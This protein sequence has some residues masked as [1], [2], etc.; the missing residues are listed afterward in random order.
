MS[1]YDIDEVKGVAGL[2]PYEKRLELKRNG[3]G[4][5]AICPWHEDHHPS[6]A[7]YERNDEFCFKCFSC[8]A[9][10]D[11]IAFV[12][13]MDGIQFKQALDEV[14]VDAGFDLQTQNH[15]FEFDLLKAVDRLPEAE[16]FLKARG[17]PLEIAR[18]RGL[19]V[20]DYPGIGLSIA[21]PYNEKVV[22]F[23]ALHPS[24]KGDKFRHLTGHP[25]SDLIYRMERL[26]DIDFVFD[27]LAR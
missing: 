7:V 24:K 8:D 21:I 20:A 26:D 15:V 27:P 10:G 23:R 16:D 1:K 13:R 9:S 6:L 5:L 19:G 2:R 17:I 14:A 3:K 25:S 22:K 11:V 4:R 12:Q 18:E